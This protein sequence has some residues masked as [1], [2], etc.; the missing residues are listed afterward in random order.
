MRKKI[1]VYYD[2]NVPDEEPSITAH[3]V[4]EEDP[5]LFTGV[6]D[7]LGN[8]IYKTRPQIGFRI[9]DKK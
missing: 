4:I 6:L 8:P 5:L 2:L 3:T 9:R 1:R 7:A